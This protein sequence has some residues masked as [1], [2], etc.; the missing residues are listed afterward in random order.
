MCV[1]DVCVHAC[2]CVCVCVCMTEDVRVGGGCGSW[3][4]RGGQGRT[5]VGVWGGGDVRWAGRQADG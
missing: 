1:C 2:M 5:G 4:T 3:E